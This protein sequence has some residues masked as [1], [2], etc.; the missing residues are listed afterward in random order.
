LS[1]KAAE[2]LSAGHVVGASPRQFVP[3]T[4][5]AKTL[6]AAN[7]ERKDNEL[8]AAFTTSQQLRGNDPPPS[9]SVAAVRWYK[10]TRP[11]NAG[12]E[13]EKKN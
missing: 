4:D 6:Q 9:F 11:K 12:Y 3:V 7:E 13:K 2:R 10:G 5:D 8:Q 1:A